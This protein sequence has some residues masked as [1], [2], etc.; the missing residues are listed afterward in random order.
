MSLLIYRNH[1][2]SGERTEGLAS[3]GDYQTWFLRSTDDGR[4]WVMDPQPLGPGPLSD[5]TVMAPAVQLP[6]GRRFLPVASCLC[7]PPSASIFVSEDNGQT[8][9]FHS[10]IG[11]LPASYVSSFP[12]T[13]L[14]RAPS[15]R[16]IALIRVNYGPHLQSTSEDEGRTW[17]SWKETELFS[18][19]HRARLTTLRSGELLCSYGWR[20]RRQEGLDDFG[21]IKLALS[22][23]E[24]QT[25]A[26]ADRRILRDDFLNWDIGYPITLELS[27]GQFF[28][29]YWGNHMD[30]FYIA[31]NV[32]RKWWS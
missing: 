23:D 5:V 1:D 25:W 6:D 22:R 30:R 13:T 10:L 16:L 11:E 26:A 28:T 21:A 7:T 24:G 3:S 32:Y 4:S 12:E 17:T 27:D 20:C 8:W 2:A 18:F 29:A 19:G 14:A 31:G 15:G 9:C